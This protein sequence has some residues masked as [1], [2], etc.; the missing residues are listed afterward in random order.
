MMR[1]TAYLYYY[2]ETSQILVRQRKTIRGVP[3]IRAREGPAY[4]SIFHAI[5]VQLRSCVVKSRLLEH[6]RLVNGSFPAAQ[7]RRSIRLSHHVT[8]GIGGARGIVLRTRGNATKQPNASSP[9]L[10]W[11][12]NHDYLRNG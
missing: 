12:T 5:G 4:S 10:K 6:P 7:K 8:A 11:S 1:W 9:L 3:G 2:D